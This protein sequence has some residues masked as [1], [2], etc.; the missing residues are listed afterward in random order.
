LAS[1]SECATTPSSMRRHRRRR[2]L[3]LLTHE[4]CR[5]LLV[6]LELPSERIE[7]TR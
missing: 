1:T 2:R 5:L 3:G 7:L 4:L 6:S